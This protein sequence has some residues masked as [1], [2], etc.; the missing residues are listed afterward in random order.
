MAP[1]AAADARGTGSQSELVKKCAWP[2]KPAML[3]TSVKRLDGPDKVTG[4]AKYTFD[5][6]RPGMIYGRMVRSP[7]PHA[8]IVVHRSVGGAEGSWRQAALEHKQAGAQVMYQGDAVAGVAADTEERAI[9]A[10]R[11]VEVQYEVLPHLANVEQAMAGR[12]VVFPSGNTRAGQTQ[13]AAIWTAGFSAGRAHRRSDL[14]DARHHARLHGEAMR[15][16][17]VGRRQADRVDLDA[18]RPRLRAAVRQRL[19]IP[20]T[21]VRVIT[22]YMGGGFGSK[23]QI[24]A[25]GSLCAKLAKA[26]KAPVKLML[27]RKEEHLDTG[28]RPSAT[29]HIKAGVA[30][31]G[32]LTA[33]DARE[34]GH[35][36]CGRRHRTSRFPTST[37]SPIAAAPTRTSTSTP[38]SSGR[39][40]RQDIPR[41]ASS[42]KS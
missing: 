4:R 35:R 2:E 27:D 23:S 26:A 19:K 42:P 7:H 3:G 31:D 9:D 10:A 18:G 41:G 1:P 30:A 22:Q 29:A 16:V 37:N 6:N 11:L 28:N 13:R 25:K 40:A 36:R 24:G 17:R 34:L 5:I 14:L 12:A 39:C 33:F 8:R 21:N 15:R 20:Q 38:A 32:M